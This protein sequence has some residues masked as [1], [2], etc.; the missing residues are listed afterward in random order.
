MKID[1]EPDAES[2]SS[3]TLPRLLRV[4]EGAA[5]AKTTTT[6]RAMGI[7]ANISTACNALTPLA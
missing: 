1:S 5:T 3:V 4:H 6:A 2:N 7:P